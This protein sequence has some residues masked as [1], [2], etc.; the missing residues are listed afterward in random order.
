MGL[1]DELRTRAGS[2]AEWQAGGI[3]AAT[4]IVLTW[5]GLAALCG[6]WIYAAFSKS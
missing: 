4:V 3:V 6:A 2:N 1:I 5:L